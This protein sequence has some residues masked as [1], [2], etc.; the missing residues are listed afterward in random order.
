[1]SENIKKTIDLRVD[2]LRQIKN[3]L[4]IL[5]AFTILKN[6]I[7][8]GKK[9]LI[10]GNG[11][12]ATQSSHFAAELVNKFYVDRPGIAAIALT[13]DMANIT[14][15]A[16]DRHFNK[17]FSR[18]IEALGERDDVVIGL[19]TSGKSAN[20]IEGLRSAKNL[21]LKTI[22]LCG[23]HT[24]PMQ[25]LNLDVVL[26]IPSEDTPIIQEMHLLI[27]HLL[28]EMLETENIK[29]LKSKNNGK[30]W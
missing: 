8:S 21:Q 29:L 15:I 3:D 23:Q 9:I 6:S 27:L 22:C 19:S 13:A 2:L 10:F 16:N 24:A 28:A 4:N 26:A 30:K 7:G 12:S 25:P 1:L 14:S 18:Q 5:P 17:V 20:V 11:G